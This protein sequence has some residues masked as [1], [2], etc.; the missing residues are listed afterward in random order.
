MTEQVSEVEAQEEVANL[1]VQIR[2]AFDANQGKEEDE[3][4]LAMITAGATFKNVT[5]LFNQFMV[6]SGLAVSK[7]EKDQI[8]LEVAGANDISTEEGFDAAVAA[9]VERITGTTEKSAAALIRAY[10]KKNEVEVFKKAKGGSG[11]PRTGFNAKYF[12]F[13]AANPTC[14]K[15][16]AEEFI[17]NSEFSSENV[18]RHKSKHL[19]VHALV[20]RIAGVEA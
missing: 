18:R 1:E 7:E 10:G 13:L 2:E 14:S 17:N 3:I 4:K 9:L 20:N 6:D 12:D 11:A 15:E 16:E 19:A 8:V 5:R